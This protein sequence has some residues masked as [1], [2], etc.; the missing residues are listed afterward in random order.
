[1]DLYNHVSEIFANMDHEFA[2]FRKSKPESKILTFFRERNIS[3]KYAKS[4]QGLHTIGVF[5]NKKVC[6]P[7]FII[8]GPNDLFYG[9]FV[10]S[11]KNGLGCHLYSNGFVYIGDYCEDKKVN[12]I[13]IE[14]ATGE[15]IY[16]GGWH[17]DNYAGSGKLRN[18]YQ[19]CI[20]EGDFARGLFDGFG[21]LIWSTGDYYEG[22][23]KQGRMHGNGTLVLINQGTYSGCFNG[24]TFHGRGSIRYA[25]GDNYNG[26][27]E[28]GSIHNPGDLNFSE[29]ISVRGEWS[30]N[31]SQRV[32]YSVQGLELEF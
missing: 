3:V 28:R 4:N 1:M 32:I 19:N 23:F 12:G 7:A 21:K 30:N 27:F 20:Y 18:P 9:E 15:D 11:K 29:G 26:N 24:G 31:Q 17:E 8:Y 25:T 6:G 22:Q 5:K 14:R 16:R 13:V 2:L 10:E